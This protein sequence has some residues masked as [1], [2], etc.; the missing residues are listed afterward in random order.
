MRTNRIF[1]SEL[2]NSNSEET[3]SDDSDNE[4]DFISEWCEKLKIFP[5]NNFSEEMVYP[6]FLFLKRD[7]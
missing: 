4:D 1:L 5:F 2:Q 7:Y 6:W 3:E